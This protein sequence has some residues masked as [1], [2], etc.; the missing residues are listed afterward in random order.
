QAR[1]GVDH[2]TF[3][4][5]D[6]RQGLSSYPQIAASAL[7]RRDLE[8]AGR[9]RD[10]L[11]KWNRPTTRRLHPKVRAL[12]DLVRVITL[13]EIEKVRAGRCSRPTATG[14]TSP[15]SWGTKICASAWDSRS[16]TLTER[17]SS[18]AASSRCACC[19]P[20]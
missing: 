1:E 9:L 11:S 14:A 8:S 5:T 10:L 12:V 19:G 17:F 20:S 2:R 16:S 18:G 7:L 13:D 6:L 4:S 15:Q 3:I